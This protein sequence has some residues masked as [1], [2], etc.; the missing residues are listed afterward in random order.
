[1]RKLSEILKLVL[2]ELEN[3]PRSI[4]ISLDN[5]ANRGDI[6]REE[7]TVA[8]MEFAKQHNHQFKSGRLPS[9]TNETRKKFVELW[10]NKMEGVGR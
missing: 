3:R 7:Y 6:T 2:S 9:W 10:R 4:L 1:M 5:L 8:E